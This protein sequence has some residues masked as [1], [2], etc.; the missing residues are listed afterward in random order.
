MQTQKQLA[1]QNIANISSTI[2]TGAKRNGVVLKNAISVTTKKGMKNTTTPTHTQLIDH[3]LTQNTIN[4]YEQCRAIILAMVTQE[5]AEKLQT[6]GSVKK[7]K[8]QQDKLH[9]LIR[10]AMHLKEHGQWANYNK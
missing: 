1:Q 8:A 10:I 5:C 9:S 6:Y 2:T 4:N 3:V 7:Q